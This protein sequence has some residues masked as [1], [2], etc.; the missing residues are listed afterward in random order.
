MSHADQGHALVLNGL[1][2]DRAVFG[3]AVDV[4]STTTG[5]KAPSA[6]TD[7]APLGRVTVHATAGKETIYFALVFVTGELRFDLAKDVRAEGEG[8]KENEK[9]G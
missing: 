2:V 9:D 8:E 5:R 6:G 1:V 4:A 7:G 3:L